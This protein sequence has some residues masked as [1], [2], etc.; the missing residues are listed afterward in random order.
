MLKTGYFANVQNNGYTL[1]P[2]NEVKKYGQIN[3][4]NNTTITQE[5]DTTKARC[6]TSAVILDVKSPIDANEMVA[7]G[8]EAAEEDK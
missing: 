8:D 5:G 1:N 2:E 4:P 3:L 7:Y 6:F